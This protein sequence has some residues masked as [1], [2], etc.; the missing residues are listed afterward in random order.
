VTPASSS[1]RQVACPIA[2]L[3]PVMTATWPMVV[4]P[5]LALLRPR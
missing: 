5:R 4:S 1:L 2:P 3:L